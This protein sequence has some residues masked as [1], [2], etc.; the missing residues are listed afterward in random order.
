[1]KNIIMENFIPVIDSNNNLECL[2]I[3]HSRSLCKVYEEKNRRNKIKFFEN[4]IR[5][6]EEEI[7]IRERDHENKISE[8]KKDIELYN[9]QLLPLLKEVKK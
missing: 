1:M 5:I 6:L 4:E 8:I 7:R 2:Y 9:K 3:Y